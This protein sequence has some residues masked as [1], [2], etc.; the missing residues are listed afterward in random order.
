MQGFIKHQNHTSTLKYVSIYHVGFQYSKPATREDVREERFAGG[1]ETTYHPLLFAG[2]YMRSLWEGG[3]DG[4]GG[5]LGGGEA[6][7]RGEEEEEVR[8]KGQGERQQRR[9]QS[10]ITTPTF[11]QSIILTV[12]PL[13]MTQ[14]STLI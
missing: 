5:G 14:T 1:S 10:F 11:I 9:G 4:R 8:R 3:G 13:W 7:G 2:A 6:G 12:V